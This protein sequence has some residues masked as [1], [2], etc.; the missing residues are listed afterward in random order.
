[1]EKVWYKWY[2]TQVPRSI[3]YPPSPLKDFFNYHTEKT[4]DKPYLIINDITISYAQSNGL[5]RRFANALL[6]MG[7]KKGRP[8]GAHVAE[9]TAVCHRAPG[10]FQGSA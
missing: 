3:Y 8:S 5:A 4:P 7:V 1:M 6:G 2:D 9:R 10:L